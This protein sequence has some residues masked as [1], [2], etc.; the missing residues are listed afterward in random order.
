MATLGKVYEHHGILYHE[1]KK[2]EQTQIQT[3][4]TLK[5]KNNYDSFE[6]DPIEIQAAK[7]PYFLKVSKIR[8]VI[9]VTE[10]V[11]TLRSYKGWRNSLY[12]AG[13]TNAIVQQDEQRLLTLA[14]LEHVDHYFWESVFAES[15]KQEI[16]IDRAMAIVQFNHRITMELSP[17]LLLPKGP[18]LKREAPPDKADKKGNKKQKGRKG[19]DKGK[20]P[21][22][23]APPPKKQY[24]WIKGVQKLM[25][26]YEH[27]YNSEG[28]KCPT[29]I[30]IEQDEKT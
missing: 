21:E 11:C 3:D 4:G 16:T 28:G 29:Q 24:Y 15:S 14:E 10:G 9:Y 18:P 5:V 7:T 22:S 12:Q 26:F 2:V 27:G 1:N 6:M 8:E 20:T 23:E 25:P 19:G 30:L 17:K 13:Y